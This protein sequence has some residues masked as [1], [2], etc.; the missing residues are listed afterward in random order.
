[1]HYRELV[2]LVYINCFINIQRFLSIFKSGEKMCSLRHPTAP[3]P[4]ISQKPY[5]P[6]SQ[7]FYKGHSHSVEPCCCT[8]D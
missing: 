7:Q 6:I 8:K 3:S 5:N 4:P 1:M 2:S